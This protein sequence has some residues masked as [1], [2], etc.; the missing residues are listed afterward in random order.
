LGWQEYA[1]EHRPDLQRLEQQSPLP[2]QASPRTRQLPPGT[3]AHEP[4]VHVLVQHC[5]ASVQAWPVAVHAALPHEPL[6]QALLQH[7]ESTAQATPGSLQNV[8]ERQ[9]APAQPPQH[10]VFASHAWPAAMHWPPSLEPPSPPGGVT[11][12]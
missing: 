10:G 6:T 7:S 8:E 11:P 3:C 1:F 12:H 4:A 5:A 2:V 9:T